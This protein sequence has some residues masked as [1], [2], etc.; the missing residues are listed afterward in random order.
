[1]KLKQYLYEE[2]SKDINAI[3]K[4][5]LT[6]CSN[7]DKVWKLIRTYDDKNETDVWGKIARNSQKADGLLNDILTIAIAEIKKDVKKPLV[8]R[9][10]QR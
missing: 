4:R 6:A 1:M 3:E 10:M 5:F 8:I 2:K 7:L 9:R